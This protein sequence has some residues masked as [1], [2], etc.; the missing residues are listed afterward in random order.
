MNN[1]HYVIKKFF[2]RAKLIILV[3]I[4][5]LLLMPISYSNLSNSTALG[6]TDT[7]KLQDLYNQKSK[8]STDI[9][10]KTKAATEKKKQAEELAKTIKTID[11][12]I[13]ETESKINSLQAQMAQTQ[14][15][16]EK[17]ENQI[18]EKEKELDRE[19]NNK[20]ET[21]R[22]IY[23][24]G[25]YNTIELLIGSATLSEAIDHSQYFELLEN[26][27]ETTISEINKL[28]SELET[29]KEELNKK[30]DELKKMKAEQEA[31]K[32]GLSDQK[33]QKDVVLK[34]TKAQQKSLEEQVAESKKYSSQVEAQ[35]ASI[36]ASLNQSSSGRTVLARDRGTSAVGFS[37]PADYKYISA[38]YGEPTPFQSFH[39]GI[40]LVNIAGTPI[41]AA[42]DGTVVVAAG[43]MM[44]GGY[45]GYG[46]Y[47][48]I[49]H[50]AK[51]SSLYGHLMGF[52]VSAGDEVK[53]GDV[54]G[55]LGTTGWSTGPHLH[56]EVWEN[57]A[58]Q[59]PLNYLP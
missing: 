2:Q 27:I 4:A 26:R 9:N 45:Y 15:E 14:G 40:D 6:A 48:V 38:Y 11:G 34:D 44:D 25:Q 59:N 7:S 1:I 46:N 30:R 22:E 28:K 37:W 17:T 52:A 41:H 56:F 58:R 32:Q 43:M 18:R 16:I 10:Q 12:N 51:Y 29:K 8:L 39:T 3:V 57:G 21:L 19:T 13:A 50:N 35:I 55:Y 53:K 54:I 20:Y 42:A 24:G 47:V 5:A 33:S 49:G 23:T 31:Y 36:Q